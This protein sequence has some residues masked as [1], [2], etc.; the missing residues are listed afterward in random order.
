MSSR[1]LDGTIGP[2]LVVHGK[3]EGKSDLR[4]EGTFEG[5]IDVDGTVS[6]GPDGTV[7]GPARV[8]SLEVE[9]ELHGDADASGSVAVRAGGRLTGDVR[10]RQVAIDD[11][12][13]LQGGID[14][15]FEVPGRAR[16]AS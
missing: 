6:I 9:G 4:I 1:R 2:D 15:D 14:M 3:L 8:G 13:S 11:G 7:R 16:G 10:A 5:E 12:G